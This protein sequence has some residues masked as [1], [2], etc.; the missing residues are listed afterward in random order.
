MGLWHFIPPGSADPPRYQLTN[1]RS[2][3]LING[4]PWKMVSRRQRCLILADGFYESEKPAGAKGTVTWRYYSMADRAP[5]AFAGLW[6]EIADQ[7]TG[8]VLDGYTIVT[9]DANSVIHMHER[10]PAILDPDNYERWLEPG[11]VPVDLLWRYPADRMRGSRV[12]DAAPSS[13]SPDTAALIEPVD[14]A[15]LL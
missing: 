7:R 3:K 12:G 11:A 10:M 13:R 14:A 5:F 4:W 15:P 8:E 1:A 6:V 2:D 9:T